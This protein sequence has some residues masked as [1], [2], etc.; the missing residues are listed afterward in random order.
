MIRAQNIS[1]LTDFLRNHKQHIAHLKESGEPEVLT[2]NGK[3]EVIVQDAES[4]QSILDALDRF[5]LAEAIRR[6]N[7]DIAA[8]RVVTLEQ[9]QERIDAIKAE[10]RRSI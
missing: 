8:G 6:G 10:T 2:V 1:S 3:A 5:E 4:Y 7:E 9:M